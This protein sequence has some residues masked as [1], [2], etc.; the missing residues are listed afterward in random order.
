[1]LGERSAAQLL[2]CKRKF[3]SYSE[4]VIFRSDFINTAGVMM[5][6]K[7][8]ITV[9]PTV[10]FYEADRAARVRRDNGARYTAFR[11]VL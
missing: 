8:N 1:M 3:T 5:V 10:P 9:Q 11:S 7:A 4:K 6:V 2:P